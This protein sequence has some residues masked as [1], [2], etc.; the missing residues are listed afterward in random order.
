[1]QHGIF[2]AP[3]GPFADP[4]RL[5]DLGRAVEESGWD[6][7][8]V[9][10]HVLRPE[11]NEII[12]TWVALAALATATQKVRLG[13]MVVPVPRRRLMKLVREVLTLDLLS[14]GR[15]TLGVGSGTDTGGELA[16]FDEVIDPR[17][18]GRRLDEGL[19]IVA[20]LLEGE[21]VVHFG[22]HY[23]VDGVSAEPL[24]VQRPRPPI[25]CA[26]RGS[27]MKPV[28]RAARYEGMFPIEVDHDSFCRALDEVAAVRGDL[29]G[30]DVCL[31]TEF[32]GTPPPFAHWGATWL[33]RSFPAVSD[34]VTVFAAVVRGPPR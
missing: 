23:I 26:A 3:F 29:N 10:D 28:R 17:I 21:F 22:E 20:R 25:W 7:L 33:L 32:D 16:R 19:R 4:H 24:T 18:R 6:G 1:M 14:E 15:L 30:F 27:A 2:V 11:S 5:M 12:D 31:R 13:P 8:F 9:W 34:P